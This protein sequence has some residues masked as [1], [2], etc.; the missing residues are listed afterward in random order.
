VIKITINATGSED[1][2]QRQ[3]LIEVTDG[4]TDV[5]IH[6]LTETVDIDQGEREIDI[7]NLLNLGQ[8]PKHGAIGLTTVTI[9][10]YPQQAGTAAAGA[11]TGFFDI[12]ASKPAI[13]SSGELDVDISN[14]LT[15]YRVAIL[16]TNDATADEGA[17]A[18]ASG[19]LGMRFVMADCFCTSCKTTFTDGILKQTLMFKGTAF[20]KDGGA[21]AS[22]IKQKWESCT[23]SEA[24]TALGSYTPGTTMWA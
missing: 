10:G 1:A 17:D 14:T 5:D 3:C 6:A 15:R 13:D 2:W 8:I 11:A 18:V 16:W 7:I 23:A 24:L 19:S 9:E 22:G 12:F 20:G 21:A 4:T